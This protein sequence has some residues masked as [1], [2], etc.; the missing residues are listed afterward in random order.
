MSA[1]EIIEQIK[2]LPLEEQQQVREF[3]QAKEQNAVEPPVE[4]IPRSDLERTA[5]EIFK[6]HETLFRKLAQ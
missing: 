1:A 3:L 6:K 5:K 2:R 4:Y